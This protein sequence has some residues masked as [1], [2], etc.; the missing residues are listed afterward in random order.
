MK[1]RIRLGS[2][3]VLC[4]LAFALLPATAFAQFPS[5]AAWVRFLDVRC[6]DIPNQLPIGVPLQL[7]HLNPYFQSLGLP[8]EDVKLNE[9]QQLCVPVV[10][11]NQFPPDDVRRILQWLDWKC[12]GIEGPSLDLTVRL[13]QLN[14]VIRNMF[15]P[16]VKV[17]VREPQQLCVPVAKN[18]RFPPLGALDL[19]QWL[20]VKCYRVESDQIVGGQIQLTHLNPLFANIPPEVAHFVAGSSPVQLCVPV[21]KDKNFPP[22]HVYN[23]I[24]YSD[25][26]CYQ[27]RGLPLNMNLRLDH[28]NPVLRAMGLAPE[29]VFVGET[30]ELCVPVAKEGWFPPG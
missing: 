18:Q 28:L 23:Q 26:L 2:V 27:L 1:K 9:A 29:F 15:G 4:L 3:S 11:N 16:E 6:Y 13:D 25:V 8:P 19:I 30:E 12:Y 10:K 24:A 7:D 21:A 20:D 5:P 17:L 14:P 22:H